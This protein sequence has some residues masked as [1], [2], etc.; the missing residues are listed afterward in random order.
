MSHLNRKLHKLTVLLIPMTVMIMLAS[1]KKHSDSPSS[2]ARPDDIIGTWELRNSMYCCGHENVDDA[3]PGNGRRY[4]F[5][6]SN[7]WE[8]Y[9]AD[10]LYYTEAYS[11]RLDTVPYTTTVKYRID[12]RGIPVFVER[13]AESLTVYFGL[14]PFGGTVEKYVKID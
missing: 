11:L 1:C 8:W 6:S 10:T 13:N 14:V 2:P 4:K 7:T 12:L 9:Q 5:T 3:K